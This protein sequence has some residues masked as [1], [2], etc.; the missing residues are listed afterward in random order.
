MTLSGHDGSVVD[1]A[2]TPDG[3]RALSASEDNTLKVWDLESG[4]ALLTLSGHD[5]LVN[6][7]AVT[8]DG[9]RAVSASDDNN[10]KVW[11][12]APAEQ[13][14]ASA[15]VLTDRPLDCADIAGPDR[16]GYAP[17]AAALL[18]LISH[19]DTG[20]PLSMAVSAPWGSGKTSIMRWVQCELDMHRSRAT[21]TC[22]VIPG[23]REW[24]AKADG[25]RRS[26][27]RLAHLW[28]WSANS[29]PAPGD[30]SPESEGEDLGLARRCRT[31]WIDAWRYESSAALWAAFTKEIYQQGQQQLGGPL[32][33][34]K[35]RLA[36]ANAV[37]PGD[38]TLSD[39]PRLRT[40]DLHGLVSVH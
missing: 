18:Q 5:D 10:L 14:H 24:R 28:P 20:L 23:V 25:D 34:L 2:V 27:S 33:R 15:S 6:G 13:T 4:Q 3:R 36:L 8:P 38:K 26:P 22:T 9:R 30:G 29:K 19:G 40:V 39:E 31:V 37:E 16:L 1:V 11:V 21:H 32:N 35:F 12:I 17:Y 7:V